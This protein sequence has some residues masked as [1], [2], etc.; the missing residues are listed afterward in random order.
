MDTFIELFTITPQPL[1][2][3][4]IANSD[5]IRSHPQ[6]S[7]SRLF[8]ILLDSSLAFSRNKLALLFYTSCLFSFL[9]CL[10]YGFNVFH[11]ADILA[12]SEMVVETALIS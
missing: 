4:I 7:L 3:S 12:H 8:L 1:S 11:L 6:S 10:L 9:E 2:S 5:P